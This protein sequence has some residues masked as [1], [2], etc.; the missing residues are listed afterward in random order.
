MKIIRPGNQSY[1]GVVAPGQPISHAFKV[2]IA[3]ASYNYTSDASPPQPVPPGEITHVTGAQMIKVSNVDTDGNEWSPVFLAMR[4]GDLITIGADTYTL[5]GSPGP[6]Q[7]Q[8][9]IPLTTVPT[10]V[11]GSYIVKVARP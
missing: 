10:T 8:W 11:T 3:G 6:S 7:G 2:R 4:G 9:N 1:A 5:A